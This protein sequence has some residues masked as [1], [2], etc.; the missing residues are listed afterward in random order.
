MRFAKLIVITSTLLL[1]ACSEKIEVQYG[2]IRT[3]H[4]INAEEAFQMNLEELNSKF[5][6]N[7]ITAVDATFRGCAYRIGIA[8]ACILT[9][10]LIDT[11]PVTFDGQYE[12]MKIE[13]FLNYTEEYHHIYAKRF[14]YNITPSNEHFEEMIY[15]KEDTSQEACWSPE[16]KSLRKPRIPEKPWIDCEYSQPDLRISGTV[17]DIELYNEED[18]K[19]ITFYVVPTGLSY[20]FEKSYF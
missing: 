19:E 16:D 2:E 5:L 12:R 18:L 3:D 1:L 9:F 11:P 17:F 4:I 8:N 6:N 13:F 7:T 20:S 10:S 14:G 15:A